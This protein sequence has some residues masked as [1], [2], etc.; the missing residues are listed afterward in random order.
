MSSIVEFELSKKDL[1][2]QLQSGQNSCS[3]QT[4]KILAF[5]NIKRFDLSF[6]SRKFY[7]NK[8]SKGFVITLD[9][10]IAIFIVFS[11]LTISIHYLNLQNQEKNYLYLQTLAQDSLTSLEKSNILTNTISNKTSKDLRVFVNNLPANI[12]GSIVVYDS[13]KSTVSVEKRECYASSDKVTMYRSFLYS[14][15]MYYIKTT[16]WYG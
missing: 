4:N 8:L 5:A 9:L 1:P 7:K 3:K 6:T 14:D 2:S 11:L 10:I 16:L 12:C 15:S 13:T